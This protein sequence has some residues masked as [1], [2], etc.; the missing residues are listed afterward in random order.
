MNSRQRR[1]VILLLLSVLC[2]FGAFAG[3]L[4]VISDV[5]SKVGPEVS[6]Y[7]LKDDVAPYKQLDAGQFEKISMPKR[8]L[9]ANAV[10]DISEV[11]GKIAVTQLQR[12]SL[13]QSDMIV[14]KPELGSGEQEIAIMIDAATGVA[15][16]IN[17]GSRVNI[18]AT[19]EGEDEGQPNKSQVIVSGA[20][21]LD[22]GKITALEPGKNDRS[23]RATD[24][25]PIT[26]ALNTLDAQRVAYAESF[27][28]HVRLAL[29]ADGSD[30]TISPRD[31]EYTLDG[32]K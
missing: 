10:T 8:W 24:A 2:A 1:G 29:V 21:V 4:S 19:F 32:D 18:Y 14:K 23:R 25:V 13:L 31:R 5:N 3:V 16:K 12:G 22:V 9:S 28:E 17:P 7:R 30:T 11:R 20:R 27:A 6:A 15:G 26:F